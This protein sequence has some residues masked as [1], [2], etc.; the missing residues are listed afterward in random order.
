MKQLA[1]GIDIGGTN[2]VFGLVD[3][4][5]N[6]Y[7]EGVIP[8]K[9]YPDFDQYLEELYIGIQSIIKAY[10]EPCELVGIGIGAPNANYYQG[11]I[12]NAANL[13]WQGRVPFVEKFKKYFPNL[14]VII[15]NDANAAAIGEMMYGAAKGMRDFIVVTLGT[16]LGSG[17]VANGEMIYGSDSYAGELGH[18]VISGG[19]RQCGCGRKGCLET[20]VSAT[21]IKRTAFKLLADHL[22]ES[23]FRNVT[24]N[25]LTAEMITKAAL[26]GDPLAIEAYEYTGMMLGKALADAVTITSPEAIILF[27]G[28]AKAGKYIFEPTK[29]SMEMNM[30][31]NFRNKV[32]LL[33]S[34]ISGKNAAV[35]GASSLAWQEREKGRK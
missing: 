8:T 2:S 11:T 6:M 15:T 10:D 29:R 17:F 12:E 13:I 26:A 20:Y 24:Y 21:G 31:R 25:D 27:G 14:P 5:G 33:P 1:V 28:L 9:K 23:E 3:R 19:E 35:L 18:V 32:K 4:E 16:G 7:G 22:E 34:G 30:L